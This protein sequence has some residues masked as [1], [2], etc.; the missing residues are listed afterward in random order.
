[1]R[2]DWLALDVATFSSVTNVRSPARK[3]RAGPEEEREGER[4]RERERDGERVGGGERY[5]ARPQRAVHEEMNERRNG[6]SERLAGPRSLS[7]LHSK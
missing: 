4:G 7:I 5:S 2:S 6:G 1:M 3:Y